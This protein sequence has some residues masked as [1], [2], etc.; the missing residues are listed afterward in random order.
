M[1][2][3]DFRKEYGKY[4]MS[5]YVFPGMRIAEDSLF[6]KLLG[7]TGTTSAMKIEVMKR[8]NWFTD[9]YEISAGGIIL[10]KLGTQ[11]EYITSPMPFDHKMAPF[12]WG[13]M[14]PLDEKLAYGLSTTFQSKDPH[15]ILNT[16]YT[17]MVEREL[18]AVDPAILSS[19]IDSPDIIFGQHK[20]IPVNDVNA[21]KEFTI[22]EPSNQ[23]FNMMNSMQSTMTSSNQGGDASVVPSR[24]PSSARE[25]MY[26][27]QLKQQALSNA[28]TMYYDILRQQV[29]LVCKTALQFYTTDKYKN[30]DKNTVRTITVSNMPLTDG[31]IG[32]IKM[33][34]VKE[35]KLD[36]DLFIEAIKESVM[37]GKKTEILEIPVDFIQNLE[38][39][40]NDIKLEPDNASEIEL[41][42][43][44]ENVIGPMINVY[45]PAGLADPAK[46]MMRHVE[47]MGE[48]ISDY[49]SDNNAS[50]MMSGGTPQAMPQGQEGAGQTQGNLLQS[51]VGMQNGV[52]QGGSLTPKFGS[53]NAKP[54][55]LNN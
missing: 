22:A 31:G 21:Y 5:K 7:G 1:D 25:V 17:M 55:P 19:D 32:T 9:D 46:V 33:R 37:N 53:A 10:N 12:T 40:V 3:A 36:T 42:N 8:Y 34:F 43:F 44:V 49:V 26:N 6:F 38:F 27:S 47:K 48:S 50:S 20:V 15:K 45:I 4:P 29:M 11:D 14:S 23:F 35:K 16:A 30:A 28:T 39:M 13:I 2:E 24:Q 41:A 52:N 54:L 18:R 51:T